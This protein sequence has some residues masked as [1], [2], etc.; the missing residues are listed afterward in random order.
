MKIVIGLGNPGEQYKHTRHN[1]GWL[2]L[3]YMVEHGGFGKQYETEEFDSILWQVE[4]AR[5]AEGAGS[6]KLMF[7][8]PH[9]FM[10]SSGEAVAK[11]VDY[12]KLSPADIIVIHDDVDLPL[13]TIKFTDNSG[14][15]GHNGVKSIIENLGTQEFRRIRIGIESREVADIPPTEAFVL[16][17]FTPEELKKLPLDAVAARVMLELKPK[18]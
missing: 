1:A 4:A 5:T 6:D 2:A 13:G 15:A 17:P 10:N 18:S 7:M 16:Q 12:Y 14:A 3:N 8:Y 9:T 11:M